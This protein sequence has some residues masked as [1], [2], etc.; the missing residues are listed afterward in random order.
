[1]SSIA[2]SAQGTLFKIESGTSAGSF[3]TIPECIK[4]KAPN[5]KFDLKDVTS[6]DSAGGFREYLP[7][8]AD[9]DNATAEL[10]FV[11]TNAIHTQIRTDAYAK[12]RRN[13]HIVFAGAGTG[14]EIDFGAYIVDYPAQ[15]DAGEVLKN[16]MT[17]KV[18]GQPTWV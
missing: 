11:P 14:G 10:N 16:T 3:V 13:F 12:T 4:I 17:T 9:G 6:H 2:I 18:T 5:V 8:L 15:A 7:G 1:M